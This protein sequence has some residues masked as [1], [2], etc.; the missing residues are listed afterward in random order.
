MRKSTTGKSVEYDG[1]IEKLINDVIP[2]HFSVE[3][4]KDAEERIRN[5]S[6][7]YSKA[8]TGNNEWVED[9]EKKEDR[10]TPAIQDASDWIAEHLRDLTDVNLKCCYR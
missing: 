10:A 3:M 1:I 5:V 6:K 2:N 8:K 7:T 4:T 9:S